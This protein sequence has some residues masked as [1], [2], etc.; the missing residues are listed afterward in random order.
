MSS[1]C[2]L[3]GNSFPLT[4]MRRKVTVEPLPLAALRAAAAG[5]GVASFWG[6]VDTVK[7]ASAATGIDLAPAVDRPAL[8]LSPE[9]LPMFGGQIFRECWVVSPDYRRS[10]RPAENRPVD[11]EEIVGWQCLKI[12]W[13]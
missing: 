3:V 11:A 12:T 6:H 13:I 1:D 8:E 10:F 5:K 7:T 9:A 2:I 4:L